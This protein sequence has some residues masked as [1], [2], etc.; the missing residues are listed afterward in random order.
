MI[1]VTYRDK[2]W[3]LSG[4]KT[5]REIIQEVGLN[6]ATVLAVRN[7]KLVL[8]FGYTPEDGTTFTLLD[9]LSFTGSFDDIEILGLDAGSLDLSQLAA[10]GRDKMAQAL[11]LFFL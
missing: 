11:D 1:K 2:H 6:P 9:F 7:G 8:D 5:I 10:M 4:D 3:E